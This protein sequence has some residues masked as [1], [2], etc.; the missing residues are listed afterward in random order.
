M[1][2]SKPGKLTNQ[3]KIRKQAMDA[4]RRGD[5]QEYNRLMQLFREAGKKK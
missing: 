4:A 5:T 1:F 3:L 2:G